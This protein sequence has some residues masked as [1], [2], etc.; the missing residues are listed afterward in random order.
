DGDFTD[1]LP[2]VDNSQTYSI[3]LSDPD[4]IDVGSGYDVYFQLKPAGGAY[5]LLDGTQ[6]TTT[7]QAV[8]C[9]TT[10][11]VVS[12]YT[13]TLDFAAF[14]LNGSIPAG[15]YVLQAYAEDTTLPYG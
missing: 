15:S 14:N 8:D 2:N 3:N 9:V 7:S 11:G 5:E 4:E 13:C 6:I 1:G 10:V 12:S